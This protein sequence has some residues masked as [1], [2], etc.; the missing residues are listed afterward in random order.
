MVS[1]ERAFNSDQNFQAG[2]FKFCSGADNQ[3]TNL[4]TLRQRGG[5]SAAQLEAEQ[6]SFEQGINP[7]KTYY[8][9]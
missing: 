2:I 1:S 6:P 8:K 7:R 5:S 9:K 3:A 4:S